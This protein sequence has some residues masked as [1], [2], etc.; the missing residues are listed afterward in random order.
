MRTVL[1]VSQDIDLKQRA[2]AS[3]SQRGCQVLCAT[4]PIQ[5]LNLARLALPDVIV[6]DDELSS[7]DSFCAGGILQAQLSTRGVPV[8]VLVA[9][10]KFWLRQHVTA[11]D[12][13]QIA[14]MPVE[15]EALGDLVLDC[16]E[17]QVP[18]MELQAG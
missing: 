15:V 1:F 5:G 14:Q 13:P 10:G 6:L 3:L 9:A 18:P 17:P 8:I 4:N 16:F 7:S 12:T 11:L 2:S